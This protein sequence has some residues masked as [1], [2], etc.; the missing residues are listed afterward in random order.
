MS[1]ENSRNGKS[2]VKIAFVTTRPDKASFKFRVMQ[3]VPYLK[4]SG[5]KHEILILPRGFFARRLFYKKLKNFDVVFLQK[6][7]SGKWD[8]RDLFNNSNRLIYDLDDS[9]MFNDG[10]NDDFY[11]K[12]LELRFRRMVMRAD[13]VVVGNE[14]LGKLAS[15]YIDRRKLMTI[16][17]VVDM[18]IWDARFRQPA[19]RKAIIVGWV[20]SQST[21]PYWKER[22]STWKR[23]CEKFPQVIFRVVCNEVTAI[24]ALPEYAGI[25]L[26]PVEWT[27]DSQVEN[28]A[29][30][31]IGIMPLPDNPWTRGK[32]GFKLIQYLSLGIPAVASPVGV[33]TDIIRHGQTGLL[34]D[35]EEAW[36]EN[37]GKLIE[38]RERRHFLGNNGYRHIRENYSLQAWLSSFQS[39]FEF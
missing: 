38:S 11:S 28:C 8:L 1:P 9:V 15:R 32:C 21:L 2:P 22:A 30:F 16:P 34:A 7:L 29:S 17:S 20:G 25:A 4:E 36:L 39:L 13:R 10:I 24:A 23:I 6:R 37:L 35:S 27:E 33:N 18:N 19:E 26:Q 5:I 12:K 14:F 31:D 3:Y